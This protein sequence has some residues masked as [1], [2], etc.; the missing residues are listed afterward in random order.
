MMAANALLALAEAGVVLLLDG[1]RLR[2]RAPAGALTD[3]LRGALE[4]S[5][6][7]PL[8]QFFDQWLRRP[9]V[10][11]PSI[12]WAYDSSAAT[13]S[14]LVLQ[15][16]ARAYAL[17]LTVELTDSLGASRRLEVEVPARPRAELTLPGRF[18]A[19]P[20]SIVFDP[21][22]FLLARISRP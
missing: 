13:V 16:S 22:L 10:A 7:R 20:V 5:S 21:D 11:T 4:K 2:F 8:G 1:G 15:D 17:P 12:G 9:G 3:D 14:L 18:A 6:G 19:R